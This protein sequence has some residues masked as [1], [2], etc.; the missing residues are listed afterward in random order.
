MGATPIPVDV[1][2]SFHLD[3]DMVEKAIGPKTKSILTI[4]MWA[5]P[6]MAKFESLCKKFN[7]TLIED[8]AQCLGGTYEG[9]KLGT[10][11]KIGS[12]S[13]D[14]G[15]TITTGEGGM[16]ITNEKDLY[17]RA[18]EFSDNGHMHDDSVPRGKDPR[19]F[20]G[21][22][23]RMGEVNAAI[24]LAQLEKISDILQTQREHLKTL[25]Q[26][27][28]GLKGLTLRPIDFSGNCGILIFTLDSERSSKQ[29]A[30]HL[31]ESSVPN[32]ILPEA[33]EWHFSGSWQHIFPDKLLEWQ[34]TRNLLT[35]S[36]GIPVKL[37][38]KQSDLMHI[39]EATK[40]A[41]SLQS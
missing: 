37:S 31:S 11:G 41:L 13:F 30:Q 2:E 14:S 34:N 38:Y 26:H 33:F 18:A 40:K 15:K 1:D 4:P 27:L 23:Y 12:F 32:A 36:I 5:S 10:I 3:P 35:R 21:L 9:R 39:V 29:M 28:T 8:A 20:T 16:I 19:R 6:K 7:L 17:E 22:N 24:G 25:Y